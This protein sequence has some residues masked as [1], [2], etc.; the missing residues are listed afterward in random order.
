M[1]KVVAHVEERD[2]NKVGGRRRK[3]Y[4]NTKGKPIVSSWS[5]IYAGGGWHC[6]GCHAQGLFKGSGACKDEEKNVRAHRSSDEYEEF[7]DEAGKVVKTPSV[8]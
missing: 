8:A 3:W 4:W 7:N 2:E 5:P 6:E 1:N